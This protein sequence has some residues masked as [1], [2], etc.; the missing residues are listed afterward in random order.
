MKESGIVGGQVRLPGR[1][2]SHPQGTPPAIVAKLS[3]VLTKIMHDPE[4]ADKWDGIGMLPVA[5]GPDEFA[6]VIRE[7]IETNKVLIQ[8]GAYHAGLGRLRRDRN[9]AWVM[10]FADAQ[11]ILRSDRGANP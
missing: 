10:G 8:Q 11:P 2:C 5:L 3:A 7:D 1:A 4:L 6:K 9:P